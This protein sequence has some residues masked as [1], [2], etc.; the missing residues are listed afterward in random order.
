MEEFSIFF[1]SFFLNMSIMLAIIA[2]TQRY[3]RG[4]A[5]KVL[6]IRN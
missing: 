2:E 3:D 5:Y 4:S 6:C 1:Y